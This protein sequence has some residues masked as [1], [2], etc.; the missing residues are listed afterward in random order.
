M[1]L[2]KFLLAGF[3]PARVWRFWK[4][5]NSFDGHFSFVN[6]SGLEVEWVE[7]DGFGDCNPPVGL[8]VI[9]GRAESVMGYNGAPYPNNCT[10]TY[11]LRGQ[12]DQSVVLTLNTIPVEARVGILEFSFSPE[13]IWTFRFIP[14]Y[15]P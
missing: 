2:L 7:V 13:H 4:R 11:R 10:I 14:E 12:S 5:K 6:R 15:M 8:F 9:G 3:V 1:R